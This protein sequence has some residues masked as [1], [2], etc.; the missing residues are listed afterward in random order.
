MNYGVTFL[1][2]CFYNYYL[3][4]KSICYHRLTAFFDMY[5]QTEF[6]RCRLREVSFGSDLP[7]KMVFEGYVLVLLILQGKTNQSLDVL[8]L[9]EHV[10][11]GCGG[12]FVGGGKGEEVAG[13]GGRIAGNIDD[14]TRAGGEKRI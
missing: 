12:D 3:I 9:R 13:K 10:V 8:G 14:L 6:C 4:E 7:L 2:L 5:P 11:G 1:I